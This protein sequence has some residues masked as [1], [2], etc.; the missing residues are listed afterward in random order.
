MRDDPF[1]DAVRAGNDK[2]ISWRSKS[3]AASGNKRQIPAVESLEKRHPLEEARPDDLF[4]DGFDLASGKMEE[5]IN[6]GFGEDLGQ[7]LEDFFSRLAGRSASRGRGPTFTFS[8][9]LIIQ[10]FYG[11]KH[12]SLKWEPLASYKKRI[13]LRPGVFNLEGNRLA[14][15]SSRRPFCNSRI[16]RPP[17]PFWPLVNGGA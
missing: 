1:G 11:R 12:I 7:G 15:P 14:F 9:V 4:L 6:G 16:I 3:S 13:F 5:R 8:I 10:N 17:P 2:I